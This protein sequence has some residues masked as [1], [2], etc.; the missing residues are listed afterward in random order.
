[1]FKLGARKETKRLCTSERIHSVKAGSGH[2]STTLKRQRVVA[3]LRRTLNRNLAKLERALPHRLATRVTF[4]LKSIS[5]IE[6]G[7][8]AQVAMKLEFAE[9]T[10]DPSPIDP[11]WVLEGN[12]IARNKL[13]SV[14]ADGAAS[15]YIWDCTAGRF[16]WFYGAEETIY[17]IEGG[18]VIRLSG[19]PAR[20]LR[21]GDTFFFPAGVRA[22]WHVENYI[23]KFA[24]I[25][26][27][28][29]RPLVLA[30]RG[31]RFLKRLV[32]HGGNAAPLFGNNRE[33]I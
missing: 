13:V 32:G 22:E 7:M 27:P 18:V 3:A 8:S 10:L 21:A 26:T 14:S 19:S 9:E 16:N 31:Y 1:M 6:G 25:R 24:L 11:S 5:W 28:L 12:P 23:R 15:S 17:V 4:T 20:R 29:P 30:K 33:F 2:R